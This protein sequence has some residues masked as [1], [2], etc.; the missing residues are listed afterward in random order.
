MNGFIKVTLFV[1]VCIFLQAKTFA[2]KPYNE[3][4]VSH[5]N[6]Y[7]YPKEIAAHA[8]DVE[9]TIGDLH[10][11][12]L[13]LLN[14][15]IRNDVV[16]I[17][18]K[19]YQLFVAIY[20]KNPN[21][22]TSKDLALFHIILNTAQINRGHKIRFLGDDLCDRGM[23]DYYTLAIYKRLDTASVPFEVVLSNHGN[24]FLT[25]YERPEQSFSYNPYGEGENE[26]LVQSMLHLGTIIDRGLVDK[27]EVLDIIQNHYLKHLVLPGYTL[28]SAKNEITLYSHAPVDI[29]MLAALA[30]DLEVP[31]H[32][33]TL[34]EL[35]LSLDEINKHI[36]HWLITNTFTANYWRLNGEHKKDNTQ[37]PLKQV[38][39]NRDYTI[40]KRAYHPE[41]KSYTV[42]YV[43]G[44]D[45]MPNV[46]DLDNLFGKGG[47]KEYKGPYAVHVTHS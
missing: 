17:P 23:N 10:G 11:N 7:H 36:H 1:M 39:W 47:Y 14:F 16:K 42:N 13:K 32:D 19:E 28:T 21:E 44:H 43:H 45:S 8:P 29:A 9:V 4:Q 37:S 6:L 15:L 18:E 35:R 33:N 24:F 46:F 26:S 2:H 25:A 20:K 34:D 5:V 41:N 3:L 31:F 22:L 40:L 12:A 27:K 38:L 30:N